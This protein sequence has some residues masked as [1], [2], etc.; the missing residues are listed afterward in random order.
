MQCKNKFKQVSLAVLNYAG[1]NKDTLPAIIDPAY[2]Y[3]NGTPEPDVDLTWMYSVLPY[4]EEQA[5]YDLF[6]ITRRRPWFRQSVHRVHANSAD[7]D[8]SLYLPGGAGFPA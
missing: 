2:D 3:D 8:G 4:L 6:A 1:V 5:T 7:R